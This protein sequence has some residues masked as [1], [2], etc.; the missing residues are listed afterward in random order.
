MDGFR[1]SLFIRDLED[2][3]NDMAQTATECAPFVHE[4]AADA[5]FGAINIR[6][7]D[8]DRVREFL[9]R[10]ENPKFIKSIKCV[11]SREEVK[12]V[13]DSVELNDRIA[14]LHEEVQMLV[15]M[16]L[17]VGNTPEVRARLENAVR[18]MRSLT[19]L[20]KPVLVRGSN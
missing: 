8:E 13:A 18:H 19:P 15:S 17:Q 16:S 10:L 1:L 3:A 20:E 14:A 7:L 6:W 4:W 5:D 11:R 12:K 2:D 9:S